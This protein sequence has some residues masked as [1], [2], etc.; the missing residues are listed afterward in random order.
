MKRIFIIS[1]EL[2]GDIHGAGL[3]REIIARA[4]DTEFLGLGGPRMNEV[5][6]S[7]EDWVE[8][9]AVVGISEVIQ[10]YSWFK[11][12]LAACMESIAR[13]K[14]DAV[15]LIDYTGFN[16]R[17]AKAIHKQQL[18]T[19]TIYF[20]SPQ[21]WA[22]RKGRIK[23]MA[24][25]LDLMICIFPFEKPLYEKSGLRTEFAGHPMV[26][27]VKELRRPWQREPGLVG[28]F[29]GSRKAE[30]KRLFPVMI[31]AAKIIKHNVPEAR[32]AIS[33]ANEKLAGL[34]SELADTIGFPESK[35]WIETGTFYDLMQRAETGAVASGTATLEAACFGLP[36]ALIY[37]VA[38]PTYFVA[39]AVMSIDHIG[40]I[41]VLAQ[42]EV[43]QE[44]LQSDCTPETLAKSMT[45]LLRS[46]EKR[47]A[48]Q[49]DL[50]AVV[51]TLGEG[52]AYIKAA[53]LALNAI[54]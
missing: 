48:L 12:R 40:I 18:K 54:P 6:P 53:E 52:G 27:R 4:P 45:D 32:F 23:E 51:A 14:P 25:T 31:E 38:W 19:Q 35:A 39:K 42:R 21:V 33:A 49:K 22:W 1:G 28:F 47:E 46:R 30:V 9:A 37:K 29:P 5:A 7:I 16:L 17:I 11:Q 41:N 10:R 34:M 20:I 3:M 2:S 26:D 15:I 13:E 24:Q 8:S 50:A 36:Y 44:L 43:V